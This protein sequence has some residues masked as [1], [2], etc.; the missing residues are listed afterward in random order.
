[1]KQK[2]STDPVIKKKIRLIQQIQADLTEVIV[3]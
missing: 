2:F 3:D 1:M